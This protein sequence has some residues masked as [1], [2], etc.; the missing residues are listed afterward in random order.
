MFNNFS[1]MN[2]IRGITS[3]FIPKLY[4]VCKSYLKN[5]KNGLFFLQNHLVFLIDFPISSKLPTSLEF[6]TLSHLKIIFP[7]FFYYLSTRS[8]IYVEF[9]APTKAPIV[10]SACPI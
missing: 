4:I 8:K 1:L 10:V 6:Y 2:K 7:P 9:L 5:L 3:F